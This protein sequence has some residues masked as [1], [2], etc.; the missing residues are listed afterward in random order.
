[1]TRNKHLKDRVRARM[2][3]TGERYTAARRH[4]LNAQPP[5]AYELRGGLHPDTAAI[6]GVLANRGM[7][8]PH[9]GQPP[10]EALVLGV[11]GG[12]GAGYILWEFA[13]G[14]SRLVVLGF[15]NRWQ[16]PDRWAG[17]T[18]R[19]LGVP[20]EL[21]ETGSRKQAEASL[22][23]A[24]SAGIPAV[25]WVDDQVLRLRH[26]PRQLCG[27]FGHPLVVYG[28]DEDRGALLDDRNRAPVHVG[29]DVLAD[30]RAQIP[31]FRQRLLLLDAPAAELDADG[32]LA[33]VRAGLAGQVEHLSAASASFSLPAIRKW[34]R[35]V[36]DTRNAKSWPRVFADRAGLFDVLV[37]VF[38]AVQPVGPGG[39][40]LRGLYA[41]FLDEAAALTGTDGLRDAAGAYRRVAGRWAEVAQAAAPAG[42]EPF[43]EARRLLAELAVA[44]EAGDGGQEAAARAAGRLWALRGRWQDEFPL[45]Q[46]EVEA[47]LAGLGERLWAVHQAETAAL[48]TLAEVVPDA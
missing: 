38:E 3:R 40:H 32:L 18:C 6:A 27:V 9:T 1:M 12:L 17:D 30:A 4:V 28:L 11:G 45:G 14:P 39:G 13:S 47:L 23:E 34:A 35:L 37:S 41:D 2:E 26:L 15:R 24:V 19:R 16:Y 7:V 33:G 10:S 21:R 43:A 8:A 48:A 22:L 42:V 44:L 25:A 5:E 36:T 29:L 20:F 31:S 46:A